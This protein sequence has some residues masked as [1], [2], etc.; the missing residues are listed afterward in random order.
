MSFVISICTDFS[1]LA[2]DFP[3]LIDSDS[4]SIMR[5][6]LKSW[7]GDYT[8]Y[9]GN[10]SMK[11]LTG[12]DGLGAI[13]E[14]DYIIVTSYEEIF[15]YK[16]QLEID[17]VPQFEEVTTVVPAY[18]PQVIVGYEDDL[19]KPIYVVERIVTETTRTVTDMDGI[20]TVV[21]GRPIIEYVTTDVVDGYHKK[22]VYADGEEVPESTITEMVPVYE[23]VAGNP[24][25]KALYD[26]VY[27]RTQVVDVEGNVHTPPKLFAVPGGASLWHLL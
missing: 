6:R 22:P 19:T 13:A 1:R 12:T 9:N 8:W 24:D 7:S 5:G 27:P 3:E 10:Q 23:D 16:R 18:T 21:E 2:A 14:K 17:D 20:E 4:G 25:M 11:V 26:Q 15:G